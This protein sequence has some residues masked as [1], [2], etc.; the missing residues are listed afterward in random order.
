MTVADALM[1]LRDSKVT[2]EMLDVLDILESLEQKES[3][4][5]LV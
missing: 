5:I 4:D 1:V 2:L 3:V